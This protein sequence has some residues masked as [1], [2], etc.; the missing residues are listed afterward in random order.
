MNK[1]D[2]T[3]LELIN[4]LVTTEGTLKSLRDTVLTVEQ[5]F[6]KRKSTEKKKTKFAK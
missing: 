4:I 2:C 3:I 6:F 5:I 1:F